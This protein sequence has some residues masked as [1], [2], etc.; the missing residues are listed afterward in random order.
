MRAL[1]VILLS[2]LSLGFIIETP[3]TRRDQERTEKKW[4]KELS[5][6]FDFG[7]LR[8]FLMREI[9]AHPQVDGVELSKAKIGRKWSPTGIA[10]SCGDWLF[11]ADS[12]DAMRFKITWAYEK[13]EAKDGLILERSV[14]FYCVRNSKTEF[15][16]DRVERSDDEL[17]V[18]LP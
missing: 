13:N 16:V 5:A 7:E 17:V 12:P 15:S 4:H 8:G 10:R 11:V 14:T 1:A 6:H 3:E 9:R 2:V 18:L